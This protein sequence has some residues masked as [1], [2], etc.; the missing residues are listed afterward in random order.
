M[1]VVEFFLTPR[2]HLHPNAI[3]LNKNALCLKQRGSVSVT[4]NQEPELMES[5]S[6]CRVMV[7][8]KETQ[9]SHH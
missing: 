6:L 5:P 8:W 4:Y 9:F 3:T 7:E 1:K 2:S